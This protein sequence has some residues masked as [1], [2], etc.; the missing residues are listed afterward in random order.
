V[1]VSL[2][3][4]VNSHIGAGIVA[5]VSLLTV[6]IAPALAQQSVNASSKSSPASSS[7][8]LSNPQAG[9]S[10][11]T[12][13]ES[14]ANAAE[15]VWP[16][17]KPPAGWMTD[18]K[19]QTNQTTGFLTRDDAVKLA[20]EQ[21]SAYQ[22]ARFDE[23][24]A[25]EDVK[26]A[27][28]AFLPKFTLPVAVNYNT[29]IIGTPAPGEV[30]AGQANGSG[31]V[32]SFIAQNAVTE[33]LAGPS[34]SG[35]IDLSGSLRA[36]LRRERALL[37]AAHAGTEA[38]RLTLIQAAEEAYFNLSL[39]AARRNSAA[40]NLA[41]AQDFERIT[42]LLYNGGEVASVDVTRARLQSTQRRDELEQARA[43]EAAAGD[44]LKAMIGYDMTAPVAA[45]DLLI[46]LPAQDEINAFTPAM[47]G[48]RPE[49][50]QFEAQRQAAEQDANIA[51]AERRPQLS[52]T[53]TGGFDTD[54]VLAARLREH[55]GVLAE[56][57]LNI[58]IFDWGASRS[59]E[60]Q[61]N[62]KV[63][64][65]DSQRTQTT[66]Q[67]NQQFYAAK[68]QAESA[69]ARIQITRAGLAD[70]EQNVTT[71]V[72]RYRAGE[73][74]ILEVT[75]AQTTL[76]AARAAVSQAIFDYQVALSR[77]RQATGK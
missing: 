36:T 27:H 13:Q 37:A 60:R 48:D 10:Q 28:I 8:V 43:A 55:T 12:S 74:P 56:V 4:R 20:L 58:P 68:A 62:L 33:F 76:A 35:N 34:V 29:P 73:A 66:R 30:V 11:R 57:S 46:E 2:F 23:L 67:F 45:V 19:P 59:R 32:P 41:A 75:D 15:A 71:S 53:V 50:A 38:A 69:A 25:S 6:L 49:L 63:Q 61:A 14:S 16:L 39:A 18:S 17:V 42:N 24:I 31:Q 51:R 9:G 72:A 3:S 47:I 65:I 1:S 44:A 7:S 5:A 22:Q 40:L 70:A 21:A 54:S 77:L 52:F 26:Q 64:S